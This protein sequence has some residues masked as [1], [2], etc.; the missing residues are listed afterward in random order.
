MKQWWLFLS[1]IGSPLLIQGC[2]GLVH[3]EFSRPSTLVESGFRFNDNGI[4]ELPGLSLSIVAGNL[5]DTSSLI[6]P[7][8]IVPLPVIPIPGPT[9][10]SREDRFSIEFRFEPKE[11]S[12]SFDPGAV[13]LQ[14]GEKN[15]TPIGYTGPVI[16]VEYRGHKIAQYPP[17]HRWICQRKESSLKKAIGHVPL[18]SRTCISL[19][20]GTATPPP[21][22]RF[23]L[24]V[25]GIEKNGQ[26]FPVPLIHFEKDTGWEFATVP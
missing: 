13:R 26:P 10:P 24:R 2:A 11:G 15:L 18:Q 14:I 19:H 23:I 17:S 6:G 20:F 8:F 22:Q 12:F 16:G 9:V 5:R 7:A 1:M 21:D 25:L 3:V 4:L